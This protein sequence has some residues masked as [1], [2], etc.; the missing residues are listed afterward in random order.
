MY[1]K[2][3][4]SSLVLYRNS[5]PTLG[6]GQLEF[7][8]HP[9][10]QDQLTLRKWQIWRTDPMAK[11]TWKRVSILSNLD[12]KN[13]VHIGIPKHFGP[14]I[15]FQQSAPAPAPFQLFGDFK[16]LMGWLIPGVWSGCFFQ[17]HD[18]KIAGNPVLPIHWRTLCVS[19]WNVSRRPI[20]GPLKKV[21]QLS[22]LSALFPRGKKP[23]FFSSFFHMIFIKFQ[24]IPLPTLKRFPG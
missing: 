17:A 15:L 22:Y 13:G 11:D 2:N 10:N 1:W 19:Q 4:G 9:G 5:L 21:P 12:F 8:Q 24:H 18:T 7:S 6:E 20:L 3:M 23:M 14:L 16:I